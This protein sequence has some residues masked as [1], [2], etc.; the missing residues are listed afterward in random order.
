MSLVKVWTDVGARRPVPLIA[1]II[2][3]K[4]A[5]SYVI[6]YLSEGKDKVWRYETDK[7][8]ID[9]D[10]IAEYLCTDAES[11][12]GF[13]LTDAGGFLKIESDED[14]EP[15]SEADEEDEEEEE[16]ELIV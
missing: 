3:K 2:K 4:T 5:S 16:Y 14:Y 6:K 10:S 13:K 15:S 11:D 9:E 7:Y 12:I 8:D 1:K